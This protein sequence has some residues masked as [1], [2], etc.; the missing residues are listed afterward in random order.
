MFF[1]GTQCI[2]K[3]HSKIEDSFICYQGRF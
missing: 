1:I 2:A 3:N